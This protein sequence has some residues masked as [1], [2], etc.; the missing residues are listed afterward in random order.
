MKYTPTQVAGVTIIDL[1][2][3]RD[4]RGFSSRSFCADEFASR[5]LTFDVTQT[6][7]F[8]NYTRGTVRG[9]HHRVPPYAQTQLVRCTR[10]AIAAVAVD[11]RPGSQTYGDHTMVEL[12]AD[13]YRALFLPPFVAHGFQ[14]LIDNTEVSYQVSGEPAPSDEQGFHWNDPEFGIVWPLPVTVISERD[15]SWPSRTPSFTPIE[16]AASCLSR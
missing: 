11:I 12:T 8:F 2:P 5:G 4:H 10:G 16:R 13:N 15:A 9:L 1:E 3:Q 7:I 14:T 6:N